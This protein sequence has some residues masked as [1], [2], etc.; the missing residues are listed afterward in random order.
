VRTLGFEVS[1]H[2]PYSWCV[3][4]RDQLAPVIRRGRSRTRLG[5]A[6]R[7]AW[8]AWRHR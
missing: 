1:G 7:I 5:L 4:E 2:G 3:Y 8:V 6:M